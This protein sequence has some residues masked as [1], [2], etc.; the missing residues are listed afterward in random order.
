ME[1]AVV[2]ASANVE[3]EVVVVVGLA[4]VAAAAAAVTAPASSDINGVNSAWGTGKG[5]P[6]T[7]SPSNVA[8]RVNETIAVRQAAAS[9]RDD[10]AA[11]VNRERSASYLERLDPSPGGNR[12]TPKKVTKS[13]SPC[14]D[15]L[16]SDLEKT[17][18]QADRPA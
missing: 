6:L 1:R 18:S 16:T 15:T 2:G 9:E 4:A 10:E 7:K 5:F 11:V 17:R 13:I 8:E 3:M 14:A 12:T